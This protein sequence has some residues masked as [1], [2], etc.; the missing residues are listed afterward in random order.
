[1]QGEIFA[2]HNIVSV[3]GPV[4]A[5]MSSVEKEM[6]A[7]LRMATKKGLE[8]QLTVSRL[9]WISN[10]LGMV[11]MLGSAV[12]WASATEQA[13]QQV[14]QGDANAM[15]VRAGVVSHVCVLSHV[16]W[17]MSRVPQHLAAS[18]AAWL[19]DCTW[20]KMD[21]RRHFMGSRP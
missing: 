20:P 1:M 8:A 21:V 6:R 2:F 9:E 11:S 15:E 14:A 12:A 13:L 3:E 4:E 16:T 10:S 18:M 7:S 19:P 17:H 5:W